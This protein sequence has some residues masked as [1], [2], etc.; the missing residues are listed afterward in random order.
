M[1]G[2][3]LSSCL[4]SLCSSHIKAKWSV[5][6]D[7]LR[8]CS[9]VHHYDCLREVFERLVCVRAT[10][11]SLMLGDH[12]LCLYVYFLTRLHIVMDR[13]I[14]QQ[15][16]QRLYWIVTLN[17]FLDGEIGSRFLCAALRAEDGWRGRGKD[18]KGVNLFVF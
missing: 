8:T 1:G 11:G 17:A 16:K 18:G 5:T 2:G 6:F 4:L 15:S 13:P 7:L 3:D 9:L 12:C 14:W 10:A